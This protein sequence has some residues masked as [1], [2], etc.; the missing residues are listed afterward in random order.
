MESVKANWGIP[1][2]S[3]GWV[4]NFKLGCFCTVCYWMS[5]TR[6]HSSRVENSDRFDTVGSSLSMV[7]DLVK[8]LTWIIFNLKTLF[9]FTELN[10]NQQRVFKFKSG[11]KIIIKEKTKWRIII[12]DEHFSNYLLHKH[13]KHSLG[14]CCHRVSKFASN[15]KVY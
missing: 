12:T 3:F 13:W 15:L 5:C 6:K 8:I 14:P 1:D 2:N 9:G 7:R 10:W 11:F 4:F